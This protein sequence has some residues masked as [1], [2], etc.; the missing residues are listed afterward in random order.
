[1]DQLPITL[2]VTG[3]KAVVV[4]GGLIAS[5]KTETLIKAGMQIDVFAKD[6]QC[7]CVVECK[8]AKRPH[9]KR[10]LDKDID[11]MAAIRHD[12]ERTIFSHYRDPKRHKKIKTAWVLATRNIDIRGKDYERAE[13]S[14]VKILE[15]VQIEYYSALTSHLGEASK[16][17]FLAD[18]FPGINI[19]GLMEP[20][21]AM[22]GKLG[23]EI[24]YSFVMEP[25]QLLKIAYI[26]HRAKTAEES[27]ETY[28]RIAKKSRLKKIGQYIQEKEG[29]F[30]TSIVINIQ[31]DRPLRFDQAGEMGGRNAKLGTLYIPSKY[32]TAWVIDGQHRLLAY[33]GLE[34]AETA[35]LP[36]IAFHNLEPDVQA[37]LFVDINGEQ[38]KVPKGLLS[39]LWAT[40]HWNSDKPGEQLKALT[41]RLVKSLGDHPD[42]PLRDRIVNVGGRRTRTRNITLAALVDEIRKRHILGN[43][44]SR[45]S[46]TIT[47]GPLFVDDLETTLIRARKVISGYFKNYIDSS[48]HLKRQWD[49]GIGEGGYICTNGGLIALLR[50]LKAILDHL[51]SV[52]HVDIRRMKVSEL[53]MEIRKYQQPVCRF[54]DT[55]SAKTIQDFRDQYGGGGYRACSFALLWEVYKAHRSFDP[56]GLQQYIQ[57]QDTANNPQ[58]Y[59]IIAEIEKSIMDYVIQRLKGEYGEGLEGWWHKG[60]PNNVQDPAWKKSTDEGEYHHPEKYL[61]FIDWKEVVYKRFDLF[62]DV[63]TVDAKPREGKKKR[64][65]WFV[66][67]NEIRNIVSHPPRGGVTDA[68]L[69]YLGLVRDELLP[70][71]KGGGG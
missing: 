32:K 63:F 62:G 34:E 47:P 24:F 15:D 58:A 59:A 65:E 22:K 44:T 41:S 5:R 66:K 1:M 3:K 61:N 70:R 28:Q 52:D 10:S 7:I 23:K 11:Q 60:V 8:A 40:I 53:L 71:L 25:A 42:S 30:P 37:R 16:Y 48:E 6:E 29:I 26:A 36:V 17:Q 35:T 21:P 9:T 31:S 68:Q 39:D 45:K 27:I 19:P 54:L 18:M 12:I 2:N 50:V 43:V 38:V 14:K 33:S 64:L 67:V 57:S 13:K 20:V 49:V 55:A 46:K 56:P 4:G 51:E 69:R